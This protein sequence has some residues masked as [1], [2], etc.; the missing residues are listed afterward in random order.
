MSI[1]NVNTRQVKNSL[2]SFHTDFPVLPNTQ[3]RL[4]TKA[5]RTEQKNEMCPTE[6]RGKIHNHTEYAAN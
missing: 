3:V 5:V 1:K 2:S 4:I 6:I